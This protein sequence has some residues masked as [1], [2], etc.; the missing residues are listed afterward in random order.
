MSK[1]GGIHTFT[2]STAQEK[3]KFEDFM[4]KEAFPMAA[5][6]RGS[7]DRGGR[8]AIRSQYLIKVE[9]SSDYLWLVEASGVFE[10]H[11]FVHVFNNMYQTVADKMETFGV[12]KCSTTFEVVGGFDVGPRDSLGRPTGNPEF[13]DEI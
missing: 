6:I 1:Y 10:S 9:D 2:L 8:S 4:I 7:V 12:R 3:E 5:E 11:R 13:V